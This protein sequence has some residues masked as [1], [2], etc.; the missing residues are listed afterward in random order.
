M[1][2]NLKL[3]TLVLW[4][5][6]IVLIASPSSQAKSFTK[7]VHGPQ[8]IV[9]TILEPLKDYLQKLAYNYASQSYD[10]ILYFSAE[11]SIDCNATH[12]ELKTQ[13]VILTH[14]IRE[15]LFLNYCSTGMDKISITSKGASLIPKTQNELFFLKGVLLE[16]LDYLRIDFPWQNST[17]EYQR[18]SS[19]EERI[20]INIEYF[21]Y[22]QSLHFQQ[23]ELNNKTIRTYLFEQVA[24]RHHSYNANEMSI[25]INEDDEE[26]F[27]IDSDSKE[28]SLNNFLKNYTDNI[29]SVFRFNNYNF[30]NYYYQ[31]LRIEL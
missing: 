26:H 5:K 8:Q 29:D 24:S 20:V 25:V 15:R 4:I 9:D 14:E 7:A 13:Q 12:F 19:N 11:D 10:N 30:Q 18:V 28:V 22:I 6:F 1:E 23:R 16:K 27:F 3:K 21:G 17:L 31:W 2:V